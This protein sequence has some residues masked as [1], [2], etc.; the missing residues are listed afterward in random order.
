MADGHV[1]RLPYADFR[2]LQGRRLEGTG[3]VPDV[4]MAR[5]LLGDCV[6]DAALKWLG[7]ARRTAAL[8][9]S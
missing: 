9:A 1:L 7:E 5:S 8:G 4:E 3:V 6:Q 2:T